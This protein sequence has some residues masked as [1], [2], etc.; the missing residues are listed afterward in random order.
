[1]SSGTTI[2]NRDGE[3]AYVIYTSGTTGYPK[4]VA[5]RR[6]GLSNCM[7]GIHQIIKFK[8]GNKIACFTSVSFDIFMLESVLALYLGLTVVLA[9]DHEY[10][11]PRKMIDLII[12]HKI[13]VLQMVPSR[14]RMIQAIDD[15]FYCL[16]NIETILVGGEA[17]PETLLLKLKDVNKNLQIY[18][19]YGPT[20]TTIW[21]TISNL[22][23]KI[24]VDIGKPIKRTKL[25]LL[26]ED[27]L[28]VQSGEIGEIYIS[29]EG[30][31]KGY[32]NDAE[33]TEKTFVKL[34]ID[35]LVMAYRTGD[36]GQYDANGN[37]LC[38]GRK[39]EQIKLRGYR[40][41]L[42][43]IDENIIKVKGISE[44]AACFDDKNEKII[45]FYSGSRQL[46]NELIRQY[47]KS[48]LPRYM[49][50]S[51]FQ[52]IDSLL[53]TS[54]GKIDRKG[55]LE[56]YYTQVGREKFVAGNNSM[57]I[58]VLD[59]LKK[60]IEEQGDIQQLIYKPLSDFS[61]DSLTY[62]KLIVD[63]EEVFNIEFD[64]KFLVLTDTITIADIIEY[65]VDLKV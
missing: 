59:V 29:G 46:E 24:C 3:L 50:P 38:L 60:Y 20:E 21:S 34:E 9:N 62:I 11:N 37:L 45:L 32:V 4:A 57:A 16:K 8:A 2:S 36:L 6:V 44:A 61:L 51:S 31:A 65:L 42:S 13:Q 47:A 33:L 48:V 14:L 22:N 58:K 30:L 55:L 23:R 1:M 25:Y 19:M 49:I 53:Y 28:E 41:E 5:I 39:D 18:N 15:N 10:N 52:F 40:I 63:L 43:D 64:D 54:S 56:K 12:R 27:M 26:N 35:D 17:F 7:E